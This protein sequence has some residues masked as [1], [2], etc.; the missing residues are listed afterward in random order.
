MTYFD[1]LDYCQSIGIWVLL[2][3]MCWTFWLSKQGD[4]TSRSYLA[5]RAIHITGLI[6]LLGGNI[7]E[8]FAPRHATL[9]DYLYLAFLGALGGS[10]LLLFRHGKS[11]EKT[12]SAGQSA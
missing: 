10:S 3:G 7:L 8:D 9:G 11:R 1:M 6:L 2:I 4:F 5:A 12:A